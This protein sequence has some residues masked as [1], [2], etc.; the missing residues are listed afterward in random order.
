MNRF[1]G[2]AIRARIKG[3]MRHVYINSIVRS[4]WG[5]PMYFVEYEGKEYLITE[6][7]IKNDK[8]GNN[9]SGKRYRQ[10]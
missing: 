4:L 1:I 6:A 2:D 10:A 8:S 5:E 9:T 3:G 7:H